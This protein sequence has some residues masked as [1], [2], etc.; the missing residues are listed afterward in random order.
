MSQ[1]VH[2]V[3]LEIADQEFLV[4]VG[5]SGCGKST[6][7][8]MVAGLEDVSSGEIVIGGRVVN[9][10]APKN[11]DIAMVFQDYALYPHLNVYRNMSFGLEVRGMPTRGDPAARRAC[12]GDPRSHA[13]ARAPARPAFRRP[14]PARRHGAGDRARP[15]GVSLRRAAV[16]PRRQASRRDAHRDQEAAPGRCRP[17]SSTSPTTKWR[18]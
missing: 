14:A 13:A 16:E 3:D 7:L 2:G 4:L 1:V 11:R 18:R 5:P 6:L 15:E 9:E 17:P 12:G 8:R 10:L